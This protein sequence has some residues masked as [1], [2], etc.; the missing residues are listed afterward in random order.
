[1]PIQA[2]LQSNVVTRGVE[3]NRSKSRNPRRHTRTLNL[4]QLLR[5]FVQRKAKWAVLQGSLQHKVAHLLLVGKA[6]TDTADAVADAP[7]AIGHCQVQP[8][9][10]DDNRARAQLEL[11]MRRGDFTTCPLPR[12]PLRSSHQLPLPMWQ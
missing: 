7:L 11:P 12:V 6:V 8:G 10:D 3:E 1:M 4:A 2:T 9:S 5:L